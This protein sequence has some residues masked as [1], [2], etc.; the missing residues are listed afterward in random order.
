MAAAKPAPKKP[1]PVKAAGAVD[2]A[3]PLPSTALVTYDDHILPIFEGNCTGCHDPDEHKGGLDLTTYATAIRG[4][5][6]GK[7]I[8]PGNSGSSRLYMLVS[9]QEKPTM[10]PDEDPI[11][12]AQIGLIHRWIE[13]GAPDRSGLPHD[14]ILLSMPLGKWYQWTK[15]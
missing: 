3:E 15:F 6:S 8:V 2:N 4:G 14:V 7:T 12:K 9:H 5:G 10:P 13:A 11:D 1:A